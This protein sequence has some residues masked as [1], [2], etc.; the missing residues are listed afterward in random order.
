MQVTETATPTTRGHG[1]SFAQA[2][3]GLGAAWSSMFQR[4]SWWCA[5]AGSSGR[6]RG[7]SALP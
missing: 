5:P 3:I 1:A 7:A 4:S 2:V 6:S